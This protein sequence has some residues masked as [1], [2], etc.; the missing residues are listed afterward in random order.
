MNTERQPKG[1]WTIR[2]VK[3]IGSLGVPDKDFGS[4]ILPAV[5]NYTREEDYDYWNDYKKVHVCR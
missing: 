5:D 2:K 4:H 3:D 1:V